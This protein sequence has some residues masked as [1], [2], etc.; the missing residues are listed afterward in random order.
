MGDHHHLQ[1]QRAASI[2]KI[3]VPEKTK[4][5][6]L[7][8]VA[9]GG[10]AVSSSH[11]APAVSIA[12]PRT[13]AAKQPPQQLLAGSPRACL[14]SP[15][16]HAGSFRCRLHRGIGIG[17]SGSVGSGLHEMSKKKAGGGA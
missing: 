7:F 8:H 10:A 3:A 15:T 14:C 1:M 6:L 13:A 12:T 9:G 16:L 4:A 11:E 2:E 5:S 17:G